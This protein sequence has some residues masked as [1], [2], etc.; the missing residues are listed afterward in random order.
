MT[1]HYIAGHLPNSK[2]EKGW[3]RH[4][5]AFHP[6]TI[7]DCYRQGERLCTHDPLT[8]YIYKY[9]FIN[10]KL[11]R[12][13]GNKVFFVSCLTLQRENHYAVRPNQFYLPISAARAKLTIKSD[14]SSLLGTLEYSHDQ[15]LQCHGRN[16]KIRSRPESSSTHLPGSGKAYDQNNFS[17]EQLSLRG[18][19]SCT[20][21]LKRWPFWMAKSGQRIDFIKK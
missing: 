3:L 5:P 11:F 12:S 9:P 14:L 17:S 18:V 19:P 6:K 4:V 20:N 8:S 13:F 21:D 1:E 15:Y 7:Q 10:L 16:S 2:E